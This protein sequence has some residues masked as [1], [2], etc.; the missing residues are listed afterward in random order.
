MIID[1]GEKILKMMGY[2]VMTEK[3]GRDALE[4]YKENQIK[5]DLVRR[6]NKP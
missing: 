2:D 3:S 6:K 1:I 5:I 4:L